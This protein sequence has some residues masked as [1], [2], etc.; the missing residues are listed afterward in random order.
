MKSHKL[1]IED[2]A[3]SDKL[4]GS[5]NLTIHLDFFNLK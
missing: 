4:N 2:E 3:L 5:E 1:Q